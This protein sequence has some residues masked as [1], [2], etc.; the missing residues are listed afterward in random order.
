MWVVRFA[1]ARCQGSASWGRK[2]RGGRGAGEDWIAICHPKNKKERDGYSGPFRAEY[3]LRELGDLH[4][5]LRVVLW[6]RD[7]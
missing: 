1:P 6:A 3:R 2:A 7:P 4:Q 5:L